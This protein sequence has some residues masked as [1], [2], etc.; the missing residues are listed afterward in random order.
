MSMKIAVIGAGAWGTTLAALV[1]RAGHNAALFVRDPV[2]AREIQIQ[3]V[4]PRAQRGLILPEQIQA[5]ADLTEACDRAEVVVVAVPSQEMR[6]VGKALAPH[7]GSAIVVS[8]AKGL[9]RGTFRRMSEVLAEELGREP[10]QGICA[11]SGP[12]LA[13]EIA[14]GKPAVSVVAGTD[15]AAAEQVRDRLMSARFRLY[16][17]EDV[18]GVEM[19]GALKNIIAIG[20][21]MA[22]G[23]AVGDNAK[24]AFVTRGIAEIARLGTAVG[25]KPLTFAGLA[26]LGD[27]VATCASPLSR[28]NRVGRQLAKGQPLPEIL[29]E[30]TEVAEGVT[31]T[32][33]AHDLGQRLGVPLPITEQTY[34][35]LFQGKSSEAA[36]GELMSRE[37][38]HEFAGLDEG[39]S[40]KAQVPSSR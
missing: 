7:V 3:R 8:A 15:V 21:G 27:L 23:L 16:T 40:A 14:A 28:N 35:V 4:N 25:A 9:E 24:A 12:N 29:A 1:A 2:V 31:T 36:I 39:E 26:G 10:G 13:G 22:D 34:Q 19:G 32:E 17:N 5:T 30:M 6:R 20:A 11:L 18:I 37:A 38:K 33:V